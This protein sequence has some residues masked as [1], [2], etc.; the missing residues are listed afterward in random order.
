MIATLQKL[1]R[2]T[3]AAMARLY[4]M[5]CRERDSLSVFLFHSLFRDESEID[6]H[7]VDPMQRTTIAQFR[8]FIQYYMDQGYRFITALD[9]LNG[10]VQGGR[11]AMITF[12][13]GYFNNL[14]A[15]PILEEF[16]VPATFFI[17]SNY[18]QRHR[19]FWW[20]V[21]CRQRSAMGLSHDE[22]DEEAASLKDLSADN[23]ERKLVAEFG[24]PAF[25][26]IGEVDRPMTPEELRSFAAHRLVE[27][28]NH[29]ADHA[30]LLNYSREEAT[31][32]IASAQDWLQQATGKRPVAI[33]YPN[34]G[35]N[36]DVEC[37]AR[38]AGL[39]IGFTTRP[40]KNPTGEKLR[41]SNLM[42]L[43]RFCLH[44]EMPLSK[45][46]RTCRSDLQLYSG[47]RHLYINVQPGR[48]RA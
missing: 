9:V 28:G 39:K 2:Q 33:A 44:G 20:D 1:V 46:F 15:L 5:C 37:A 41:Q 30:I 18:L 47:L 38:E 13:D 43:G 31:R 14:L 29:T 12:D 32:Q 17:A 36:D 23:L 42:Q 35:V 6:R 21:L 10:A 11:Y 8:Q 40:H 16:N 48:G 19:A 24:E 45:Q 3:D 34:G 22:I 27:I 4:L 26:P 7:R 25:E